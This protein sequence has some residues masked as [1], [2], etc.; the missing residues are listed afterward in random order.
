VNACHTHGKDQPKIPLLAGDQEQRTRI[1][2]DGEVVSKFSNGK[3]GREKMWVSGMHARDILIVQ[4]YS[5]RFQNRNAKT[6][7]T[8]TPNTIHRREGNHR[9][10]QLPRNN[11]P[12]KK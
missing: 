6:E 8:T 4:Y 1:P 5:D 7:T 2:T 11:C 12:S 10:P 3:E 9:K